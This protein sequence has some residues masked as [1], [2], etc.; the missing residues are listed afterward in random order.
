[1]KMRRQKRPP[2]DHASKKKGKTPDLKAADVGRK[3][4]CG[5]VSRK[6]KDVL[7]DYKADRFAKDRRHR[8]KTKGG[9]VRVHAT[10][11]EPKPADGRAS[12][13]GYTTH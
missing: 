5:I 1:M 3:K 8:N 6:Y 12:Y 10:A 2:P 4:H 9:E 7:T 11:L 13:H